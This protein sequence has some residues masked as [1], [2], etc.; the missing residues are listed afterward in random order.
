MWYRKYKFQK[1]SDE[2]NE[3]DNSDKYSEIID[4][5]NKKQTELDEQEQALKSKEETISQRENDINN[6]ILR[7]Q[8]KLKEIN[9]NKQNE[10]TLALS[11][12]P[13]R[14]TKG[15]YILVKCSKIFK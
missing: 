11:K 5:I 12:E 14:N 6:K 7:V 3:Q 2:N 10:Y 13:N 8:D 15:V 1:K 9:A 4:T